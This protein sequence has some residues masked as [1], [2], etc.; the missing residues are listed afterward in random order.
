MTMSF[1]YHTIIESVVEK[2][3]YVLNE[4]IN[5]QKYE[6]ALEL[7]R[8]LQNVSSETHYVFSWN[9]TLLQRGSDK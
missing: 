2:M 3:L 7:L 1:L 8:P 6:Q 5:K 4:L 9:S